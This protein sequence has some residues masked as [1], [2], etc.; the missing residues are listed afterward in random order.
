VIIAGA[1]VC[2]VSHDS[3]LGFPGQR[4]AKGDGYWF[5]QG[6]DGQHATATIEDGDV[7]MTGKDCDSR[8]G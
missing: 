3:T 7:V 6:T 8:Q 5:C 1:C 2:Q 4:L